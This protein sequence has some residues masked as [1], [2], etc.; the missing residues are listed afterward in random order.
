M[1]ETKVVQRESTD[2]A[3]LPPLISTSL[4]HQRAVVCYGHF[5]VVET[6]ARFHC[7]QTRSV[8]EFLF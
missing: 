6:G 5:S 7:F 1:Q 2:E 8:R 4:A 3:S